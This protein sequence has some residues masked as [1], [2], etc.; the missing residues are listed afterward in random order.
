MFANSAFVV[1]GTYGLKN[2]ENVDS[3]YI[4]WCLD[5]LLQHFLHTCQKSALGVGRVLDS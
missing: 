1:F 3:L 2:F 4:A 5:S